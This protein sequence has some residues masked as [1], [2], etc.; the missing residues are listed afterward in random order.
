LYGALPL[1]LDS[2]EW[3]VVNALVEDGIF[4]VGGVLVGTIAY[5]CIVNLLGVKLLSALWAMRQMVHAFGFT[6][7]GCNRRLRGSGFGVQGLA[8]RKFKKI[9]GIFLDSRS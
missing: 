7:H 8:K 4:R 5:R 2:V 1:S 9:P 3:R 6:V